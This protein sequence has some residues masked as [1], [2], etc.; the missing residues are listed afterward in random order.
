MRFYCGNAVILHP[1]R[2][3][4]IKRCDSTVR[5]TPACVVGVDGAPPCSAAHPH[6]G[7]E[8]DARDQLPERRAEHTLCLIQ[9]HLRV[10]ISCLQWKKRC[11]NY[12]FVY[13]CLSC[14]QSPLNVWCVCITGAGENELHADSRPHVTW[15]LCNT[16]TNNADTPLTTVC[17]SVCLLLSLVT[18]ILELPRWYLSGASHQWGAPGQAGCARI[19]K[20]RLCEC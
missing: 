4:L 10:I 5:A 19:R 12:T 7:G 6:T 17:L 13:F 20:R 14:C 9:P 2:E 3:N 8:H 18:L 16:C 15:N 11:F 1:W